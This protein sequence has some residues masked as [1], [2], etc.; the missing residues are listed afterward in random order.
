MEEPAIDKA[1]GEALDRYRAAWEEEKYTAAVAEALYFSW[2]SGR[3]P[4]SLGW[5]ILAAVNIILDKRTDAERERLRDD[6]LHYTRYMT[7][8]TLHEEECRNKRSLTKAC[9]EAVK[10]LAGTPA[11]GGW[12]VN[13]AFLRHRPRSLRNRPCRPFL[14][15]LRPRRFGI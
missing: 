2:L 15:L 5:L 12:G 14:S 6:M 10:A 3:V 13:Q 7:V 1:A 8:R 9:D 4:P 11:E